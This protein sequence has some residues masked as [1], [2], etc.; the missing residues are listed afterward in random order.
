MIGHISRMKNR[1]SNKDSQRRGMSIVEL[2]F[3]AP[4][5]FFFLFSLFEIGHAFMVVNT[6]KAAT[7][8]AAREG[9]AEGVSTATVISRV[10]EILSSAFPT[11]HVTISVKDADTFDTPGMDPSTVDY[12]SL[13]SIELSD[14]EPR[15]LYIVRAEVEFGDVSL[16][17]P[18]VIPADLNLTGHSIMRHE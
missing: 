5:F 15:Q 11:A 4:V 14:A 2:A 6:L 12:S 18:S 1:I 8:K 16:I 7:R 10:D 13:P 9:S 3:V 17:L